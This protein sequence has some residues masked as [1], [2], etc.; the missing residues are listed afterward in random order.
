MGGKTIRE[1]IESHISE[2]GMTKKQFAEKIGRTQGSLNNML[3]S[4][5]WPSLEKMASVLGLS[6]QQLVSEGQPS[7][8]ELT[9]KCPYCGHDLNI[10]VE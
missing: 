2:A 6:V 8:G 3:S 4:P 10:R 5:S 7:Q 1:I 9:I